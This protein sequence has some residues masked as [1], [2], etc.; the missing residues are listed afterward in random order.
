MRVSVLSCAKLAFR[1]EDLADKKPSKIK[2]SVAKPAADKAATTAQEPGIGKIIDAVP[3]RTLS[4][5]DT[6]TQIL[7]T[8]QPDRTP[9]AEAPKEKEV[10]KP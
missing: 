2:R 5:I 6:L 4:P 9:P 10:G 1:P 7:G 8:Q 3:L